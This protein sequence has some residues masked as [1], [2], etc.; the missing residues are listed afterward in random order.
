MQKPAIS[1]NSHITI[2]LRINFSV[3]KQQFNGSDLYIRTTAGSVV[4]NNQQKI[5]GTTY[6]LKMWNW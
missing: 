4:I 1:E 3:K 6:F 2:F 5:P